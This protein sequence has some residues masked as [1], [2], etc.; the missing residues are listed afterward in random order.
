MW[1]K[2]RTSKDE[3]K[4]WH[5]LFLRGVGWQFM[6]FY[7]TFL[8]LII[9]HDQELRGGL[10]LHA[11]NNC[12][13]HYK[14][15][16]KAL[17]SLEKRTKSYQGKCKLIKGRLYTHIQKTSALSGL[18][19]EL[20][21][22]TGS[23]WQEVERDSAMWYVWLV[24]PFDAPVQIKGW[25]GEPHL[26]EPVLSGDHI[27]REK[28][29]SWNMS[30]IGDCDDD[31]KVVKTILIGKHIWRGLLSWRRGDPHGDL[32]KLTWGS[33]RADLWKGDYAWPTCLG[34]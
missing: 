18:E 31:E 12:P 9:Y 1:G 13:R 11:Y 3:N 23:G 4:E 28:L 21:S 26:E 14:R 19:N 22:G 34:E 6:E 5:S 17:D 10:W 2:I 15:I 7:L 25:A 30:C 33:G 27:S 8:C 16:P 29:T 24:T 20:S 32:W